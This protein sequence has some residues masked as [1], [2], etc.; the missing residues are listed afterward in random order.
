MV[1]G[2]LNI[3]ENKDMQ[4]KKWLVQM[5][6]TIPI[7][8]SEVQQRFLLQV[9]LSIQKNNG[10]PQVIYPLLQQN[11]KLLDDQLI[12]VLE[13]WTR[14]VVANSS[15]DFQRLTAEWIRCFGDLIQDF[16]LGNKAVNM[17]LAIVSYDLALEILCI[18][19]DREKWASLQNNRSTAYYKRIKG[20]RADNLEIAIECCQ[21]ALKVRTQADFPIQ[22]AMTQ[23]NL[24]NAYSDKIK[25]DRAENLETAIACY[26]A[27]FICQ[28]MA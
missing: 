4:K 25:E 19:V 8:N 12:F 20:D 24:A 14:A 23:N 18:E 7:N 16:S 21:K 13:A 27:G 5:K 15:S 22:W 11:L 9:L 10:N 2:M 1:L 28:G 6:Q 3:L 17:E 26:W